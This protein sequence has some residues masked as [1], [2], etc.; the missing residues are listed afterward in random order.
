MMEAA[1][2]RGEIA[3]LDVLLVDPLLQPAQI[4]R[5]RR[6]LQGRVDEA[7]QT[8]QPFRSLN[9]ARL[10]GGILPAV[11]EDQQLAPFDRKL[12]E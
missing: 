9:E 11:G 10:V 3:R 5:L 2:T 1:G 8:E 6:G 7:P 4:V 12:S